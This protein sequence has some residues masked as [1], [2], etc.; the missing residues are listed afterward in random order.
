MFTLFQQD[1]WMGGWSALLPEKTKIYSIVR[2]VDLRHQTKVA[3]GPERERGD[4]GT[5]EEKG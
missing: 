3:L 1:G 4:L 2:I 5:Q